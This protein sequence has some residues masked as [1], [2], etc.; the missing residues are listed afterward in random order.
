MGADIRLKNIIDHGGEPVADLVVRHSELCSTEVSGSAY[1]TIDEIPII[2]YWHASR[3][4][5]LLRSDRLKERINRDV[6]VDNLSMV[7]TLWRRR[8]YDY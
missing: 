8:R 1:H 6:M 2:A 5:Q 7:L 3:G 4:Q